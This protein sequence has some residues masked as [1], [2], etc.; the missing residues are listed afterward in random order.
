MRTISKGLDLPLT[1]A[2]EQS[3]SR[4]FSSSQ[5]AIL[6]RDFHG[7]K[8]TMEVQV[9]DRVKKGQV[10]LTDKKNP[11]INYTSPASGEVIEINRGAKRAFLS[12]VVKV[13]GA[14]SIDFGAHEAETI[15]TLA[16]EVV[17]AKLIDSGEW[18]ALRTRPFSK[19]PA[20]G[21]T[22][23][24][25]FV[26]ATDSRPHAPDPNV[27]INAEK[28]AFSAGVAAMSRLTDGSVFV[29]MNAMGA[30]ESSI[31]TVKVERF[32]GK[33]PAGLAGTH[34]HYLDPV[35]ANKTV[36][37]V[38][39]QDVIAIGH[40]FLSGQIYT[41]RV[42][43][44]AGPSVSHPSLVRVDRGA[45]LAGL[46]DEQV[47]H[48]QH[49]LI[50]GSVLDGFTAAG[51]E[52][53]L[54]RFHAQVSVLEEGTHREFLQFVMPGTDKFSLTGLFASWVLGKKS[55]DL[56][57]STGGS[58]RSIIPLG[59]FERLTPLDI[60]PTQLLRSLVVEDI[61]ASIDLGCLEL[62]EEDVALY[63]FAC[64]GKYEYGP[65]LRALLHKIEV[66]G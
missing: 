5:V 11:G 30:F 44:L 41:P 43:S 19:V 45:D 49:R 39:Y 25:I 2:P 17:E 60:L 42:V 57:T 50:S 46:T 54:G 3:I 12:L 66:E 24:S 13:D 55:F 16:R 4:E 9:G 59:T 58:D 61:E 29:C 26:T 6:G 28:E 31:P 48:G 53:Y 27:V 65:I 64:P 56:T 62:D 1:G 40:L 7:L 52:A 36:W 20:K 22:P 23:H 18:T 34:I 35:S 38:N 37:Q 8:P 21:S 47:A 15:P 14:E 63:T 10:L 51:A 32:E 33:H